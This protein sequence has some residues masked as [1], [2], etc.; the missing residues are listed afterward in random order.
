KKQKRGA[1]HGLQRAGNQ[2][3][4]RS[5]AAWIKLVVSLRVGKQTNDHT[6]SLL[7]VTEK[8]HRK[9]HLPAI[10]TDTFTSYESALLEI[11]GQRY[12]A[13]GKCRLRVLR[14]RQGLAYEQVK[15]VYKRGSV[16]GFEVLV[17]HGRTK[18]KHVLYLLGCKQI[19]KGVVER[20]NGT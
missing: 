16:D 18:L 7:Q 11:F 20:H 19:N 10:F 17:G 1:M 12:P 15:K 8:G 9:N 5:V 2:W 14:W 4:H 13:P 6:L 3:D